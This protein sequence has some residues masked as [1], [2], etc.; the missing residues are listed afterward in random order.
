MASTI[1]PPSGDYIASITVIVSCAV[2]FCDLLLW[3]FFILKEA[4]LIRSFLPSGYTHLSSFS[5]FWTSLQLPCVSAIDLICGFRIQYNGRFSGPFSSQPNSLLYIS[6]SLTCRQE[7]AYHPCL[8]H[9]RNGAPLPQQINHKRIQQNLH[10]IIHFMK[11]LI[12]QCR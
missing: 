12:A 4:R 6:G 11:V 1:R 9:Q 5:A 7:I 10:P 8:N 2:G 3:D